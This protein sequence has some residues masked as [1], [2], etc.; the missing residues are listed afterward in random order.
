MAGGKD[1]RPAFIRRVAEKDGQTTGHE[2]MI[3]TVEEPHLDLGKFLRDTL[4]HL[5]EVLP[6]FPPFIVGRS[7]CFVQ[8]IGVT[9][10]RRSN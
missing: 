6:H 8:Q 9:N 2:F 3:P 7:G 10:S 4:R 5:E 1:D